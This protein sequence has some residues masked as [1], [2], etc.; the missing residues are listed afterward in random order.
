MLFLII[1]KFILPELLRNM[2]QKCK[3]SRSEI[4]MFL[5][6]KLLRRGYQNCEVGQVCGTLSICCCRINQVC[7][8]V[9]MRRAARIAQIGGVRV[10]AELHASRCSHAIITIALILRAR[11]NSAA[12]II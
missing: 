8:R 5:A 7:L 12:K 6:P 4:V 10:C 9:R 2:R 1:V 3:V 11:G